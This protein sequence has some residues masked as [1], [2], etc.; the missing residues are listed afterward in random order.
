LLHTAH[1]SVAEK[2]GN[3]ATLRTK[4]EMKRFMVRP[5]VSIW[6]YEA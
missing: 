1:S 2:A 3:D 5:D 6:C 4:R